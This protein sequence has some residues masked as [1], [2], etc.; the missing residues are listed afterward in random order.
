MLID[1][2]EGRDFRVYLVPLPDTIK[3]AVRLCTDGF[4]S[5]YINASLTSENRKAT[6]KHELNHI[7][8]DDFYND[9][10]IRIVERRA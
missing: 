4:Y 6:L 1:L 5:I 3:G 8:N 9:D 10:D 2:V 7:R